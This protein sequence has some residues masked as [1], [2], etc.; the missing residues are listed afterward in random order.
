MNPKLVRINK[1]LSQL[2][3]ASRRKAD[4]M[5]A[6]GRIYV[7]GKPLLSPGAMID[8]F[9]DRI[10]V[11]GKDIDAKAAC[12]NVYIMLNKPQGYIATVRDT[13]QRRTVMDL[14]P[15]QKGLF[16]VGRLDKDTTGLLILTNDGELSHRL[17]HPSH[18]IEK[19]YEVTIPG[20]VKRSDIK[21]IEGGVDIGDSKVSC[22]KI[23]NV[24][25]HGKETVIKVKMHEGRKR[26][27]RRTFEALG[28]KIKQL[29]RVSYAGLGLDIEE[30]SCR[31]L[32]ENEISWLKKTTGLG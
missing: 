22:L 20:A 14:V 16:P 19:L 29:K 10:S 2:G 6:Q 25:D 27:V 13:H 7:N 8:T 32:Q 23:V 21:R 31:P 30:G 28:Y 26:Q 12:S 17:M 18:E 11:D 3:V 24:K 5:I 9:K 4:A 1:L 15:G